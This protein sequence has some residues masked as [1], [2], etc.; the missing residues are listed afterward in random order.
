MKFTTKLHVL[1][2]K[3][4]K[5]TL[6]NGQTYDSTKIYCQIELDQSRG[7]ARGYGVAEYGIGDSEEYAKYKHLTFPFSADAEVEI[8]SSGRVQKTQVL[9]LRPAELAKKVA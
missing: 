8:V 1:G 5:G 2:M 9:S 3:S 6:D 7:N 4:S